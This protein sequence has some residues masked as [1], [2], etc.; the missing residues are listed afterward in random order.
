MYLKNKMDKIY[1][2]INE[3][4]LLHNNKIRFNYTMIQKKQKK[5]QKE[6]QYYIMPKCIAN[7]EN[8]KFL[9]HLSLSFMLNYNSLPYIFYSNDFVKY[10]IIIENISKERLNKDFLSF[11]F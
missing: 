1:S 3:N 10:S 6:K 8:V 5:N 2:F 11:L 9:M 4:C 7:S